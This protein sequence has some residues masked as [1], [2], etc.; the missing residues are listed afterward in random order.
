[1]NR[2]VTLQNQTG[3]HARP[4]AI[5]VNQASK[6]KCDISVEKD[7]KRVNAKSIMGILSL[8]AVKGSTINII[9]NGIGEK[10]AVNTLAEIVERKFGEE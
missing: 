4:A 6:F 7:G 2:Q 3:L 10:E 8:G 5:F 1:M 9:A